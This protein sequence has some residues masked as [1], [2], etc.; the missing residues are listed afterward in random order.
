M[1]SFVV[2]KLIALLIYWGGGGFPLWFPRL[3]KIINVHGCLSEDD[4]ALVL[5]MAILHGDRY[6]GRL[7]R[8][9][10]G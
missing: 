7:L 6:L 1:P 5:V 4:M 9:V 8:P 3:L 10:I 2:Y